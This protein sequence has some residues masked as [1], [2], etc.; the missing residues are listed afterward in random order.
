MQIAVL[1]ARSR[2]VRTCAYQIDPFHRPQSEKRSQTEV[3]KSGSPSVNIASALQVILHEVLRFASDFFWLDDPFPAHTAR[4]V[5][6]V[7][8]AG[9][10]A[11]LPIRTRLGSRTDRQ[12]SIIHLA[13]FKDQT[14]S[15]DLMPTIEHFH[16]GLFAL[17]LLSE[18]NECLGY[19]AWLGH[20][21]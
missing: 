7:S 14:D 15:Q 1:R 20:L 21:I 11:A 12:A 17:F 4:G 3:N 16:F 10:A 8:P 18:I 9:L 6:S 19:T 5:L 2:G 13:M